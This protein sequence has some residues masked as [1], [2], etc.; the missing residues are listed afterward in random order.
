MET[1]TYFFASREH[2]LIYQYGGDAMQSNEQSSENEKKNKDLSKKN[3]PT[4][5]EVR[6]RLQT[7]HRER[8]RVAQVAAMNNVPMDKK[9]DMQSG[10]AQKLEIILAKMNIQ[11]DP[12]TKGLSIHLGHTDF[13]IDPKNRFHILIELT[14]EQ[15]VSPADIPKSAVPSLRKFILPGFPLE[16]I[17]RSGTE[18]LATIPPL[19]VSDTSGKPTSE[20]AWGYR[21][22]EAKVTLTIE[23]PPGRTHVV[24]ESVVTVPIHDSPPVLTPDGKPVQVPFLKAHLS[25]WKW[26]LPEWLGGKGG[27]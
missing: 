13:P 8:D 11:Y 16:G 14:P 25:Y 26:R 6:E 27:K 19:K 4:V 17:S 12:K 21:W 10:V 7:A 9:E 20:D 15:D 18:I 2:R 24:R 3:L 23:T 22:G 1:H 5:E